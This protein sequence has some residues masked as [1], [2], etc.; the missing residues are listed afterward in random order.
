MNDMQGILYTLASDPRLGSLVSD[1][2]AASLPFA[3]RYRLV[4]FILSSMVCA[5]VRDVG[6]IMDRDYQS[7]LDHLSGGKDWDLSRHSGG[8]RLLPPFGLPESRGRFGGC[9][10]ALRG[11]RSYIESVPH[12][13]ILLAPGDI[14]AN[15][16]LEAVSRL[17]RESGA[18]MTAVC[19]ADSPDETHHR[20][21]AEPDGFASKLLFAEKGST[22]GL[23][24]LEVYILKKSLLLELM[25]YCDENGRLHFHRD[26]VA[27]YLAEG[28]RIRL[29]RH[30]GYARRIHSLLGYYEASMDLRKGAVMQSL[31]PPGR[32]VRTRERADVSTYYSDTA[33]ARGCLVADGCFIEGELENCVV[34]SGVRVEKGAVLKNCVVMQDSVIGPDTDLRCVIADKSVRIGAGLTLAGNARLPIHIPKG[35]SL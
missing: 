30:E 29:Y 1:R 31:F 19:T 2:N 21:V 8:L 14:L 10:E 18:A 3:G 24:S 34:F 6:V 7:L 35:A 17:H 28:G 13:D 15:I 25:N 11:V 4:D 22:E 33:R 26:A 5:G 32:L 27:H 16:D 12:E 20:F 23:R 9:M